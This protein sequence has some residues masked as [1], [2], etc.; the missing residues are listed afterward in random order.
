MTV[1]QLVGSA[2]P[3]AAPKHPHSICWQ[4]VKGYRLPLEHVTLSPNFIVGFI[5]EEL[6][7][8]LQE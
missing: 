8:A 6:S 7:Q 2:V 3:G 4:E 1:A 5:L